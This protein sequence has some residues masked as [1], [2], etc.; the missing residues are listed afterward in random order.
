MVVWRNILTAKEG[1]FIGFRRGC[2]IRKSPGN[3]KALI[4]YIK[5]YPDRFLGSEKELKK[6]LKV[7]K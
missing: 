5:E 4:E 7:K 1:E 6:I 2:P 3:V